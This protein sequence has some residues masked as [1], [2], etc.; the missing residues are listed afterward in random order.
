MLTFGRFSSR[1]RCASDVALSAVATNQDPNPRIAQQRRRFQQ[2]LQALFHAKIPGVDR[3][4]FF[5][6]KAMPSPKFTP[7]GRRPALSKAMAF[8]K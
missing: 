8:G 5:R 7:F 1:T 3:E 4:E 2:H 6:R